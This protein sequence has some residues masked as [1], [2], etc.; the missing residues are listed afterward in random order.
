MT[1]LLEVEDLHVAFRTP[2]RQVYAVRGVSFTAPA[3]G[4]IA[5]VGE[6]GS[7]K[8]ATAA[9]LMGLLPRNGR[10]SHGAIRFA[11]Q[12]YAGANEKVWRA[13]RGR[14]IALV[15]QDPNAALNPTLTI[16]GQLAML[17]HVSADRT[18]A[19]HRA[20]GLLRSVGFEA[21]E[22][23]LARYPHEVSGGQRQR[24]LI[25]AALLNDPALIIA[26][27]PTTALDVSVQAEILHLLRTTVETRRLALLFVTHNL[28]VAAALADQILVLRR[29]EVVEAGDTKQVLTAPRSDYVR[30]LLAAAPSSGPPRSRLAVSEGA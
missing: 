18:T 3:A 11:G 27:E 8:S 1:P 13:V 7:G 10:V 21:P 6:S 22:V 5:V 30:D 20:T 23:I 4:V 25:A 14:R 16:G 19:R 9:A 2:T 15:P 24:V 17:D 28:A 12:D 29:G 26:D